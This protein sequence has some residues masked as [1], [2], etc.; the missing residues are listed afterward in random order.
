MLNL[1]SIA[2]DPEY[3]MFASPAGFETA[4]ALKQKQVLAMHDYRVYDEL[5]EIVK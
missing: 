3:L 1:I 5:R 4:D 2:L